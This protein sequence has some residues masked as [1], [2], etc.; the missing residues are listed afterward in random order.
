MHHDFSPGQIVISDFTGPSRC[1]SILGNE[2]PEKS[3]QEFDNL[4]NIKDISVIVDTYD[5]GAG[6]TWV[7]LLTSMGHVGYVPSIWV[8]KI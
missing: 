7:K 3:K 5:D 6:F 1:M 4:L 2:G 8:K